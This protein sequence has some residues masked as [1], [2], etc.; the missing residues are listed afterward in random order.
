MI[1]LAK[2][3]QRLSCHL[4]CPAFWRTASSG[5]GRSDA[6]NAAAAPGNRNAIRDQVAAVAGYS[7][8]SGGFRNTLSQL[9]VAGAIDLPLNQVTADM[10][11]HNRRSHDEH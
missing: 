4:S 10:R 3:S 6:P 11:R 1:R 8:T 7:V 2:L 5:R 9:N